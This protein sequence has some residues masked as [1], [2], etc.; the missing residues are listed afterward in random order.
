MSLKF[1]LNK[2]MKPWIEPSKNLEEKMKKALNKKFPNEPISD[3]KV[4]YENYLSVL[5][6]HN[7]RIPSSFSIFLTGEDGKNEMVVSKESNILTNYQATGVF[8]GKIELKE[9]VEEYSLTLYVELL[10]KF[11]EKNENKA[12]NDKCE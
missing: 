5:E 4:V 7:Y 8:K 6:G 11:L 2:N 9:Y 1:T 3:V 12:I 10:K